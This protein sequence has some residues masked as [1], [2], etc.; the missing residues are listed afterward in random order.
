MPKRTDAQIIDALKE[1]RGMVAVAARKLGVS[2]V[3]IY[4]RRERSEAVRDAIEEAR[5]FTTDVAELKLY[6]SIQKGEAWA[7]QFYLKTLGKE[8]G[9]SE[10]HEHE[11]SGPGGA[12][13]AHEIV[14]RH[15]IV[16]ADESDGIA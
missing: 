5:D 7:V 10:R 11:I 6:E 14:I 12:A 13:M 3:T 1:A 8:R 2:R 16:D 15:E 9:Y 4:N